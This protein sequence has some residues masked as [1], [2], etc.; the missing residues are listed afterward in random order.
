METGNF[1]VCKKADSDP[2]MLKSRGRG[3][4]T[5]DLIEKAVRDLEPIYSVVNKNIDKG[6]GL[7]GAGVSAV[8]C[9]DF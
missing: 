6:I 2:K 4:I 3:M 5:W 8:P 9:Y 1:Y 7:F